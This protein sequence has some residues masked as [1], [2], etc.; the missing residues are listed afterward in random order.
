[1][2]M[3]QA[4]DS[5]I[6]MRKLWTS[7]GQRA[8]F[9]PLAP[10]SMIC[11]WNPQEHQSTYNSK[12][13]PDLNTGNLLT[14]SW[15]GGQSGWMWLFGLLIASF[16]DSK[17]NKS[18][19]CHGPQPQRNPDVDHSSEGERERASSGPSKTA[20]A[21][22]G[23]NTGPNLKISPWA[24]SYF[25]YQVMRVIDIHQWCLWHTRLLTKK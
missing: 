21:F 4:L 20:V 7:P 14:F 16:G 25:Y 5:I 18:M 23:S 11:V 2:W 9:Q 22:G 6:L 24:F 3:V 17:I 12:E 10:V 1:M 8:R 15:V 19:S 13:W